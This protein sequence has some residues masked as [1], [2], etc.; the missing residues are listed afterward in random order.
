MIDRRPA[1][2]VRCTSVADVQAA[3]AFARSEGLPVAVRGGCHN[4]AGLSSTEGGVVI[5]LTLMNQ[6]DVDADARTAR[7]GR[8]AL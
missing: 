3:L 5:D 2:I 4:A 6:V 1:L 7:A 8:R